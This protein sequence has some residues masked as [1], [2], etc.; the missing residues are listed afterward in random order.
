MQG[1][2]WA[3]E[4]DLPW[5]HTWEEQAHPWLQHSTYV[6]LYS[7]YYTLLGGQKFNFIQLEVKQSFG[8]RIRAQTCSVTA[9]KFSGSDL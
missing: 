8:G 3:G 6:H 7:K 1:R 9:A 5:Q 4:Q 2:S